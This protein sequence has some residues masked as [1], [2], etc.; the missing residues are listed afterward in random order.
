MHSKPYIYYFEH[1]EFIDKH[2]KNGQTVALLNNESTHNKEIFEN[3]A[4]EHS[5]SLHV[6][7]AVQNYIHTCRLCIDTMEQAVRKAIS[8]NIQHVSTRVR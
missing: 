6:R 3:I 7:I 2:L 8:Q 1:F 4:H 5:D